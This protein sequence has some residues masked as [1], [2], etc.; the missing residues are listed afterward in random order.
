MLSLI[1]KCSMRTMEKT[2]ELFKIHDAKTI[3]KMDTNRE[4]ERERACMSWNSVCVH[5]AVVT[6]WN[7]NSSRFRVT[8]VRNNV[9]RETNSRQLI[10]RIEISMNRGPDTSLVP[11][12][13]RP[14]ANNMLRKRRNPIEWASFVRRKERHGRLINPWRTRSRS[15]IVTFDCGGIGWH[16]AF[17][18]LQ[19]RFD[20][21]RTRFPF[22]GCKFR[23]RD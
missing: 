7:P 17:K 12:S 21:A 10:F 8:C 9:I 23:R 20:V 4:R 16:V 6:Q 19:S 15:I 18:I 14:S 1:E 5:F 2:I 11:V 22:P 3:R 13:A